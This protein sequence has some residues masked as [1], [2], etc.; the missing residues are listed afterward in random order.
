M[1]VR[2]AKPKP[3][4]YYVRARCPGWEKSYVFRIDGEVAFPIGERGSNW[5]YPPYDLETLK[6][7]ATK[8]WDVI[9]KPPDADW[10]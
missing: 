2:R 1:V 10:W 7:N 6:A 3:A 5:G 9:E 4:V 8:Q